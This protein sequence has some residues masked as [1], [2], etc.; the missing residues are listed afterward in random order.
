MS[1]RPTKLS[2][3]AANQ[4]PFFGGEPTTFLRAFPS[5]AKLKFTVQEQVLGQNL[6]AVEFD[7]TD[8][9]SIFD[10]HNR[11]CWEGGFHV[12]PLIGEAV[13]KRNGDEAVSF[14][15]QF[16]CRGHEGTKTITLRGCRHIFIIKVQIEFKKLVQQN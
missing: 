11:D 9:P 8:I 7:E 3:S 1:Q 12:Q 15:K 13:N 14:E 5:V 2:V 16:Y 6:P 10:C 4:R